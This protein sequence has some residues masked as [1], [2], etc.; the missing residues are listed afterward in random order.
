MGAKEG[1]NMQ[2]FKTLFRI[3]GVFLLALLAA[4]IVLELILPL[5]FLSGGETNPRNIN[6]S[7]RAVYLS[8]FEQLMYPITWVAI[9]IYVNYLF[10]VA[11]SNKAVYNN[12]M[13]HVTYSYR[14]D[15]AEFWKQEWIPAL[16]ASVMFAAID[17]D[18]RALPFTFPLEVGFAFFVYRGLMAWN[19]YRWCK[20]HQRNTDAD[21]IPPSAN[22]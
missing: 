5:V 15:R 12:K 18:W 1:S 19:H 9:F 17:T 6:Q 10:S 14:E 20:R 4:Y 3:F 11:P 8:L 13:L 2:F 7:E 16:V 22:E 21:R